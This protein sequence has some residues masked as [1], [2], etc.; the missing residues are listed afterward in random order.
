MPAW[1]TNW[2]IKFWAVSLFE[3]PLNFPGGVAPM[4]NK[5]EISTVRTNSSTSDLG[6]NPA[7]VLF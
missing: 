2:T 5:L 3:L 1:I 6:T 7:F 4:I